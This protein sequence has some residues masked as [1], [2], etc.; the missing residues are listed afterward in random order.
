MRDR[1]RYG[2]LSEPVSRPFRRVVAP[3]LAAAFAALAAAP[4]AGAA[5]WTCE[6]SAIRGTVLGAQTIEPLTANKGAAA[7]APARAGLQGIT[8]GLPLPLSLSALGAET[9]LEGTTLPV[10]QQ[11]AGAVGGIAD[12]R[13]RAL[14]E[15]PITIPVPDISAIQPTVVPGVGTVDLR[16]AIGALL[17]NGRLPNADLV[18]VQ[19]IQA[20]ASGQC[21]AGRPQLLGSSQVAGLTVLGQELPLNEVVER[22][23]ALVNGENID[24]SN[25]N[26]AN[27][28]L[29]LGI[30][31]DL[32]GVRDAL[33]QALDA[34]PTISIPTTV[35][36][37]KVTPSQQIREGNKLTQRA[38]QVEVGLLGQ[39]LVDLVIGEA[40]VGFDGVECGTTSA[41]DQA[42]ECTT[43]RLV[44]ADVIPGRRVRLIGY[45]DKRY[46]G[47]TVNIIFSSTGRRVARTKV[48]RD[49]SFRTTAKMP[50]RTLRAT[51]RARYHARLA[52]VRYR[53]PRLKLVRRM[54]IASVR[55]AARRVTFTGRVL[56]P[57]GRP[58]RRIEVR[59]R[60][61]CNRWR[62]IRRITPSRSGR[63]RVTL[64]GP[65]SRLAATYR[66]ATR[67]RS[68]ASPDN[69]KTFET[70]TL[71]RFVDL[72]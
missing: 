16:P 11:K 50:P 6:G 70:F 31:I 68:S 55:T 37:I 66:F 67:V 51:N 30:T 23:V 27:I 32:P 5:G 60:I 29:P 48:R 7:C 40:S 46:I 36:Q 34:V 15:L 22:T 47:R 56:R 62:V 63:F 13:V 61:S 14:P 59:R 39:Q 43:R 49:G 3:L 28:P 38:L 41:A 10:A 8:A 72:G 4:S 42:L 25:A 12:I 57:L 35:A 65:P 44:L 26:P 58:V 69:P 52:G 33:Q 20:Y 24:P 1:L 64:S 53:T 18:R 9:T 19:A 17:P 45:A 54:Q 2:T 21:V 71:P